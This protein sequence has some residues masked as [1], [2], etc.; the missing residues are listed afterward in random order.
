MSTETIKKYEYLRWTNDEQGGAER[1]KLRTRMGWPAR[2]REK[3]AER[4]FL[5]LFFSTPAFPKKITST[6]IITPVLHPSTHGISLFSS[7]L[8]PT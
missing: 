5:L 7:S 4:N 8:E 1:E 2:E 3:A 6:I